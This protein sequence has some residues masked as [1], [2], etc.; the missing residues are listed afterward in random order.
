MRGVHRPYQVQTKLGVVQHVRTNG[1]LKKNR[2]SE[3]DIASD[4]L[5]LHSELESLDGS[6]L[7]PSVIFPPRRSQFLVW[8]GCQIQPLI[9][10]A[11]EWRT[12]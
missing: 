6:L 3:R 1:K 4:T 10:R 5:L 11:F 12:D 8:G 2:L 9:T 7:C